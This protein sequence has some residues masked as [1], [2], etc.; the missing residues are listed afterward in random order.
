MPPPK[1]FLAA[2]IR[3]RPGPIGAG[4]GGAL[5]SAIA[6]ARSPKPLV[7][8]RAYAIAYSFLG[9]N[10]VARRFAWVGSLA[11]GFA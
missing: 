2:G 6:M 1:L 5:L 4:R 3:F 7:V 8:D 11:C 9:P 10:V